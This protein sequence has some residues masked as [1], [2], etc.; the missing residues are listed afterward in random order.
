[1]KIQIKIECEVPLVPNFL[2]TPNGQ[3][4]IHAVITHGVQILT[5]WSGGDEDS[6][7]RVIMADRA[8]VNSPTAELAND[9]TA[10]CWVARGRSAG[11]A[12]SREFGPS[13]PGPPL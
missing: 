9:T 8:R 10:C 5:R 6:R 11:P 12:K 3:V 1:M 2:K 7:H 13:V 4:P